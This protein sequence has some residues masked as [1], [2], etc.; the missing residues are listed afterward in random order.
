VP[1]FEYVCG[2]CNHQFE[3]LVHGSTQAA[4]PKCRTTKLE[5]QFSKFGVGGT[6]GWVLSGKGDGSCGSCGDPRGPGS[7]STN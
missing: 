5:K 4:C 2:E 7:C 1:I 3:L 6:D